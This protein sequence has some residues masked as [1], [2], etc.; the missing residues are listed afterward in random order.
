MAFGDDVM[1]WARDIEPVTQANVV[2]IGVEMH[3]SVVHGSELT[4]ASGQPVDTGNL[5][6]SF[7]LEF[8][9][10]LVAETTTNVSYAPDVEDNVRGVKFRV[11]GAHS[12][13]DTIAGIDNIIDHVVGRRG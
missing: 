4:G 3:R 2:G 9:T 7:I 5:I 12:V 8:P 11:G 6:S 10:P 1:A 13:K